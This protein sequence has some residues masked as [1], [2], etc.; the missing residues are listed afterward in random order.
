MAAAKKETEMNEHKPG[1]VTIEL[2]KDNGKYKDDLFVGANGVG[3]LIQRGK[4]VEVPEIVAEGIEN[5]LKQEMQAAAYSEDL[6][7]EYM[8][9]LRRYS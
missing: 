7:R 8:S 2:F 9:Q 1:Y 3:Y 5:H 4:K 6:E